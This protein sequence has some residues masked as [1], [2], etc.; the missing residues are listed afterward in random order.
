MMRTTRNRLLFQVGGLMLAAGVVFGVACGDDDDNG[1]ELDDAGTTVSE[2]VDDAGTEV[3]DAVTPGAGDETP[4][5]GETPAA[6]GD[7][8]DTSQLEIAAENS[9]EF[10]KSELTASPGSVTIVFDNQEDGVVHNFALFETEDASEPL[11]ATELQPG[12][13]TDEITVDLEEGEYYY[14]CQSHPV[15]E[16]TLTVE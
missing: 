2:G 10:T 12:P 15:M 16:G 13:A 3:T 8:G 9:E 14:N 4:S 6:G 7:D 5:T 1:D 11:A